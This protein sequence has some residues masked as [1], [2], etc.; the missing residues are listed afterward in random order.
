MNADRPPPQSSQHHPDLELFQQSSTARLS[1]SSLNAG[2]ILSGSAEGGMTAAKVWRC[3]DLSWTPPILSFQIE[4]HGG[5]VLG[6]KRAEM[7][8]WTIDVTQATAT[9]AYTGRRQL[10]PNDPPLD[11]RRIAAQVAANVVSVQE[12][13][14]IDR[15]RSGSVRISGGRS[16]SNHRQADDGKSASTI[17]AGA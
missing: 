9:L 17:Y 7:Q 5:V 11:V 2:I 10:L 13:R 15:S 12:D 16:Y 14:A 6:S 8:T 1:H 4:R 3:E